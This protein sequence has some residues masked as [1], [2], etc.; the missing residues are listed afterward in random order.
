MTHHGRIPTFISSTSK[1]RLTQNCYNF[2]KM[3]KKNVYSTNIDMYIYTR[4]F[5]LLS[6]A[7]ILKL[8]VVNHTSDTLT[9]NIGYSY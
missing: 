4:V 5:F 2:S 7:T 3:K 8:K 9:K 6:L 1:L